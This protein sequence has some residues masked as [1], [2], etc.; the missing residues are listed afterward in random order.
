MLYVKNYEN[1]SKFVKVMPKI[2]RLFFSGHRTLGMHWSC[3]GALSQR[4]RKNLGEW[5]FYRNTYS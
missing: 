1:M 2:C 3:G 5:S 4:N